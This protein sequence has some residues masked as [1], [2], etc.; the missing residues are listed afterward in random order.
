MKNKI[1]I[2]ALVGV[3]L[4]GIVYGVSVLLREPE[5]LVMRLI[6]RDYED[7]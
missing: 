7:K 5:K 1:G 6:N 2:F 4:G 3:L